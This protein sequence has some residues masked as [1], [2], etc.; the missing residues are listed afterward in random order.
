MKLK[1]A[2]TWFIT[3]AALVI[4]APV[5]AAVAKVVVPP[6]PRAG[7]LV[8][9]GPID[10]QNGFPT[11]YR[12]KDSS[13]ATSRL[14]LCMPVPPAQSDPF[15]PLPILP[16]PAAPISYPDNYPNEMFYQLATASLT[17]AGVDMR[18]D[19]NLEAAYAA[20]V[21]NPGD[22]I[23]FG[24]IRIRDRKTGFAP[25]TTWR[26]THPYGIDD[27]T[28]DAKGQMNMTQDVGLSP[29]AFGMALGGRVGPFLKWD[30]AVAPAAPAGYTGDPAVTHTVVG[31][32]Y[33]T[34]FVKVEQ[35]NPD[36][37][38]TL[39]AQTDLFSISGRYATNAGVDVNRAA[40]SLQADGT[41]TVDV[42]AFSDADQSIQVKANPLGWA[43]TLLRADQT[44][45]YGRLP[46]TGGVPAGSQ[47][48]V[49]NAGDRPPTVKKANLVD[50]VT[51]TS[52]TYTAGTPGDPASN[53]LVVSASSS[54]AMNNPALTVE[55]FGPLDATG[56]ATFTTLAP[57]PT[58]TVTS[59]RGG[60][61]TVSVTAG[62][63]TTPAVLPVA[64][65]TAPDTVTVGQPVTMDGTGSTGDIT[66]WTWTQ[67]AGP[68]VTLTGAGTSTV[69]FTPSVAGAYTFELVVA[70][71]GGTSAPASRT[72][73]VTDPVPLAA[74]AGPNQ[75]AR[76]GT[77]VTLDA[78]ATTGAKSLTWTQL[79]GPAQ[80]LS[81]TTATKPTFTYSLMTLPAAAVG[82]P[83]I[84]YVPDNAP[85]TFRVTALGT[86][87]VSTATSDVTVSPTDEAITG[88]TVRY[89]TTTG[90]WRV[91]ATTSIIAGQRVTVVLG[92]AA[93][94]ETIGSALADGVGAFSVRAGALPDPRVSGATQVTVISQTGGVTTFPLNITG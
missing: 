44:R 66:T 58:V 54:D 7:S 60:T 61:A 16:N 12:D 8:Q 22:E 51:I 59:A 72:I 14:E 53:H 26:V 18:I 30:P 73:T 50:L 46:I 71:P 70:G 83:N 47:L 19:L 21:V 3:A 34:N 86:D 5:V 45:Y 31:S 56:S 38:F 92:G 82:S 75:V 10:S 69:S 74:N 27:I 81:S 15:C 42:Y 23:V 57:P 52:A 6:T 85:L 13:G 43:T 39:L 40:Y 89:R 25:G 20:A 17:A 49:V 77:V 68:A 24:R 48:D 91:T 55:G 4:V 87:G 64:A 67:T 78:S 88:G 93:T 33:G 94:G 79:S 28:A 90:Q 65:F 76:R 41:G 84:G 11:W 35:K 1:S 80:T 32:P 9:V 37:T 63:A 62:G 2:R 36:G 29:G